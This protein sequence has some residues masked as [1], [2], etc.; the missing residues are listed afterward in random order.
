MNAAPVDWKAGAAVAG[1]VGLVAGWWADPFAPSV[2]PRPTVSVEPSLAAPAVHA[3]EGRAVAASRAV[4]LGCV[5]WRQALHLTAP[6]A[7]PEDLPPALSPDEVHRGAERL[8]ERC[9][10]LEA[11]TVDCD[12][13][14]CGVAFARPM[15]ATT[16]CAFDLP[17][18]KLQVRV[19]ESMNV[20]T[21]QVLPSSWKSEESDTIESRWPLRERVLVEVMDELTPDGPP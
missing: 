20:V 4:D 2:D 15:D 10:D 13:F 21:F 12:E 14:P 16:V 18:S 9:P 17:Q 1:L 11:L 5:G 7:F 19:G 8:A 6:V 3:C